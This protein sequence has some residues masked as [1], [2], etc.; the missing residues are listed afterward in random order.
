MKYLTLLLVAPIIAFASEAMTPMEHSSVHGYNKNPV[1]KT[2]TE[3]RMNKLRNIKEDEAIEIVK[4]ETAEDVQ[5]IELT[6][7]GNFLVYK[8]TTKSY[9]VQVN[10]LD[11]TVMKKEL[12]K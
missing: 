1:L 8:A 6:H 11:G 2:K 10:A 5:K 4:K 7:S 3:Q 12:K 9:R